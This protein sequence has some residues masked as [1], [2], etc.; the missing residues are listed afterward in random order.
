MFWLAS[1]RHDLAEMSPQL[2]A[3]YRERRSCSCPEDLFATILLSSLHACR[4]SM[5]FCI[6]ED[7]ASSLVALH[8]ACEMIA[9]LPVALTLERP[10]R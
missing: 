2:F 1:I 9:A 4:E 3:T 10:S 6:L 5:H 7:K 8:A